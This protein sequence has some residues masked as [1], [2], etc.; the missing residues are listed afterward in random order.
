MILNYK[1]QISH[2]KW[3]KKRLEIFK[4]DNWECKICG[5]NEKTL[6]VHH[7]RYIKGLKIWEYP[8]TLLITLCHDCHDFVHYKGQWDWI[9][10]YEKHK[11][12]YLGEVCY[13]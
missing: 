13:G 4:Q 9:K 7:I 10:D 11:S 6:N 3:Q 8:D 12:E 5:D 1:Q 2:P